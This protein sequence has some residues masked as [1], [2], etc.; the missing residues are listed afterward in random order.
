MLGR[1]APGSY[2]FL[3]LKEALRGLREARQCWGFH[4]GSVMIH[5]AN[6]LTVNMDP[7]GKI[8]A[9][10]FRQVSMLRSFTT[11]PLGA[12]CSASLQPP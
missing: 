1:T 5:N 2:T 8:H 10:T 3:Q 4:V 9:L 7:K 11:W 6:P 12:T